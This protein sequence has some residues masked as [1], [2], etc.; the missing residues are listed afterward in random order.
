MDIQSQCDVT[1]G[2][3]PVGQPI[4]GDSRANVLGA[5]RAATAGGRCDTPSAPRSPEVKTCRQGAPGF[6]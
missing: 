1:S 2:G 6:L 4:P 3:G 5:T